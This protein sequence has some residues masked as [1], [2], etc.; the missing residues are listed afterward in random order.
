VSHGLYEIT[1]SKK[2]KYRMVSR[3]RVRVT[4]TADGFVCIDESATLV[5]VDA[6]RTR[7]GSKLAAILWRRK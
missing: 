5:N 2:F 4:R 1:L 3:G 6:W 7:F